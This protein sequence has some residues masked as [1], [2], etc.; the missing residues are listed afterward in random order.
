MNQLLLGLVFEMRVVL[1]GGAGYMGLVALRDLVKSG[2]Q[3]IAIADYNKDRARQL[4][5][6]YVSEKVRVSTQF[7]DANDHASLVKAMKGADAVA[8]CVGPFHR[9]GVKVLKAAIDAKVDMVDICD[10][11]DATQEYLALDGKVKEAGMTFIPGL[12]YTPGVTNLL[13]KHGADKL[14]RVDEIHVAWMWNAFDPGG[15]AVTEHGFHADTSDVPAYLDGKWVKVPAGSDEE[16][17]EF[18]EPIDS[19]KVF[20]V[21]HPEPIT[22]PRF[23]KGVK[24]VTCKGGQVPPI[25]GELF[26]TLADFGFASTQS[27]EVMGTSVIPRELATAVIRFHPELWRPA[28]LERLQK[29]APPRERGTAVRVEVRGKKAGKTTLY[30]GDVISEGRFVTGTSLSIGAQ[31]LARNAIKARGVLP[32]EGCINPEEF[33]TELKKR[34]ITIREKTA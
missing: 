19:Q 29:E 32:P 3:E 27:I 11:W 33:F 28:L 23:I 25:F 17:V 9:Y 12:G 5:A 4:A 8:N 13:A 22:L 2:V 7:V 15:Y 26:R 10:D 1:L 34:G 20:H 14:D 24:T 16:I 21:G 31:I 30:I 6:E 18:P